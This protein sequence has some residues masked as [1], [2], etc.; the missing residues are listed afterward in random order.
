MKKN[1]NRWKHSKP[2]YTVKTVR[3]IWYK[4]DENNNKEAD[5]VISDVNSFWVIAKWTPE[6]VGITDKRVQNLE[7]VIRW[8][9]DETPHLIQVFDSIPAEFSQRKRDIE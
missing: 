6:E 7:V 9:I 8:S 3:W 5:V 1:P 4:I 2:S